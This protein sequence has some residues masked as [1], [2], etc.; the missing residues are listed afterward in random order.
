MRHL[1]IYAL[2]L[3]CLIQSV[4]GQ[5]DPLK[6]QVT[7]Q[8]ESITLPDLFLEIKKKYNVNFSYAHELVSNR[9]K[10]KVTISNLALDLALKNILQ[11]Q[12]LE[13]EQVGK[14]I[15]L[16]R[17]NY[18]RASK[19]SFRPNPVMVTEK[20]NSNDQISPSIKRET[21]L[22]EVSSESHGP[23]V[24]EIIEP[25]PE[26]VKAAKYELLEENR[27]VKNQLKLEI[28]NLNDT[29]SKIQ[30]PKEKSQ[31]Q[32]KINR[33]MAGIESRLLQIRDSIK[34]MKTNESVEKIGYSIKNSIV[35][36]RQSMEQQ[37]DSLPQ[38]RKMF[39]PDPNVP[40]PMTE[41]DGLETRPGQLTLIYPIGTSWVGS[42][43][44]KNNLSINV[45]FGINGGTKGV[46]IGGLV[47]YDV[48]NV[49]GA[50]LSGYANIISGNLEGV[51]AS[52]N[53]NIVSR[54]ASGIQASGYFNL[55]AK[56]SN[57]GQACGFVNIVKGDNSGF[58]VSGFTNI[59]SGDVIG[60]QATGFAN[61]AG[62][63]VTGVQGAGILNLAR[64]NVYGTQIA[65]IINMAKNVHG[66]QIAL[67]NVCDSVTKGMPIGLINI[68]RK[69]GYFIGEVWANEIYFINGSY[70]LGTERFY[71]IVTLGI[72]PEMNFRYGLGLGFGTNFKL[73]TRD[74]INIDLTSF[75]NMTDE[76][77][78]NNHNRINR[79][80]ATYS[81][82]LFGGT[83]VFIG[84][85]INLL[86]ASD[87]KEN[88]Y[89]AAPSWSFYKTENT[90]NDNTKLNLW[91]GLSGG[92]R[93]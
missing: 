86:V 5:N 37:A 44:L 54:Q 9:R 39:Q 43:K 64:G 35:N 77:F 8:Y 80:Q 27:E 59:T 58:Q 84:P 41:D 81:R 90:G 72:R 68:V 62:K 82:K 21:Y 10:I 53:V 69:N 6:R 61:F 50:Q 89:N 48:K 18:S 51:Q 49:Q 63:E 32:R 73:N 19:L 93:F 45:L 66:T 29:V 52:G 60:F 7:L 87:W 3:L 42:T 75:E 11:S 76:P 91:I 57:V 70:K 46:E 78:T 67:I 17:G 40:N 28:A 55:A 2:L 1:Q 31:M 14:Q 15:V 36:V 47:N 74:A 88:K 4:Q 34:S 22:P 23:Y 71:A 26:S 85:S 56:S 33:F 79:L 65:G 13:F 92:I 30:D 25:L 83:S 38:K 20:S 12:G 16:K 24:E